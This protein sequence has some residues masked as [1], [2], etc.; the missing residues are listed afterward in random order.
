MHKIHKTLL[1]YTLFF[2]QFFSY[3]AI[4][5]KGDQENPTFSFPVAVY[6]VQSNENGLSLFTGARGINGGDF[7]IAKLNPLA[8]QFT[9]L[10][11]EKITLNKEKDTVNPY[12]NKEIT[13]L[14]ALSKNAITGPGDFAPLFVTSDDLKKI[15]LIDM[16]Y[17]DGSVSVINN[18][19]PIADASGSSETDGVVQLTTSSKGG[20]IFAAVRANGETDF[21]VGNSGIALFGVT[22]SMQSNDQTVKGPFLVQQSTSLLN[23]SSTF[24]AINSDLSSVANAVDLYW[25]QK[26]ERLFVGMSV[27]GGAAASDGA[28][29][30]VV[31]RVA[32]MMTGPNQFVSGLIFE[33]I[34]SDA[35]F[36]SLN[37]IVGAQG[38]DVALSAHKIRTLHVSN[39]YDKRNAQNLTYLIVQGGVGSVSAT[40]RSV[41][42]LPLVCFGDTATIGTL[43]KKDSA[44]EDINMGK[45]HPIRAAHCFS[46]IATVPS[47]LFTDADRAVKVGG[48]DLSVGDIDDLYVLHDTVFVS[49]GSADAGFKPGIFYSRAILDAQ[50]AIVAWTSWERFGGITDNVF[51]FLTD[52]FTGQTTYLTGVDKCSINTIKRTVWGMGSADLS[53]SLLSSLGV[54]APF[55]N[56]IQGFVNF[57]YNTSGLNSMVSLLVT[58]GNGKIIIGQSGYSN[59][60]VLCPTQGDVSQA[61]ALYQDGTITTAPVVGTKVI[62]IEGGALAAIGSIITSEIAN[63]NDNGRLFVGGSNGLAVLVDTNGDGW[64]AS[65]IGVDFEGLT[66][67]MSFKVIGNY[68]FVQKI[69]SDDN[70]LYILTPTI[71]DRIDVT[72][73][74]FATGNLS[75]VRLA[76][77]TTLLSS[78]NGTFSDVVVSGKFAAL[79]TSAGLFRVGNG[80]DIQA[81]TNSVAAGWIPVSIPF[82]L[83]PVY[84]LQTVSTTGRSQDVAKGAPGNLYV[85]TADLG[86]NLSRLSRFAL[87][88]TDAG[89]NENSMLPLSDEYQ[90][91]VDQY[92]LNPGNLVQRFMT[93]GALT[94]L[95]KNRNLLIRPIIYSNRAGIPID[96]MQSNTVVCIGKNS[97]SG[98]RVIVTDTRIFTD[99]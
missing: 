30:V 10:A 51:G 89:I 67:G 87:Q 9:S 96:V 62:S 79:G 50:D 55:N 18:T 11:P 3:A 99:E 45:I 16:V 85:L 64:G 38:A 97:A 23:V 7:T 98:S 22:D 46:E 71:L 61:I 8:T 69:I 91:G 13:L 24:L 86:N 35:V 15:Y 65:G 72:L 70:F 33:P 4:I 57:P 37:Q 60:G 59:S 32:Q 34:G 2:I 41:F 56:G 43:A 44:I 26:I 17:S 20:M 81:V 53:A 83:D 48:G 94:V 93:D 27:V 74:D 84:Q 82:G 5:I 75:V 76:E 31:G 77:A 47:D 78:F 52:D 39:T 54:Y 58:T 25:D 92:F 68:Q 42:A 6:N 14:S 28:R 12:R 29:S 36:D 49:V 63:Q 19:V 95:G 40:R 88:D 1:F 66:P 21:G 73:S 80:V 90:S